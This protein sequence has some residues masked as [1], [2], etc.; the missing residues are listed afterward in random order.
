MS[1]LLLIC[2]PRDDYSSSFPFPLKDLGIEVIHVRNGYDCLRAVR[3]G[4]PDVLL[5]SAETDSGFLSRLLN[6]IRNMI[7]GPPPPEIFL[8][9]EQSPADLSHRWDIAE[10]RCFQKPMNASHVDDLLAS[11]LGSSEVK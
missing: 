10:D 6:D 11:A 8:I 5:L 9:G 2:D 7:A 3:L 1:P 4:R